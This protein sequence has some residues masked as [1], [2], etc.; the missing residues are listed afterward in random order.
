M[1]TL[2]LHFRRTAFFICHKN[3]NKPIH[4]KISGIE[5]QFLV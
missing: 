1:P 2:E 4:F 5:W 3:E